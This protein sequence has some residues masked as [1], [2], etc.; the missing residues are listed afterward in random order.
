MKILDYELIDDISRLFEK[1][2][3]V[4]GTGKYG[5]K[6]A[7]AFSR[8]KIKI[9]GFCE[10]K[11]DKIFFDGE[12]VI[13]A[14]SLIQDYDEDN[15]LVI[16]ASEKYYKEMISALQVTQ[17][18]N[19][20]TYY[21][22]FLSLYLNCEAKE[23]IEPIKKDIKFFKEVSL[24][25]AIQTFFD[26]WRTTRFY[27]EMMA[28]PSLVWLLQPGKVASMTIHSSNFLKTYHFHSM[29]Y[30][31]NADGNMRDLCNQM[32]DNIKE[33]P[34][35]IITGVREPIARDISVF[36]QGTEWD[37]WPLI[38]YDNSWLYLFGDYKDNN[39]K[40]LD[41]KLLKKEI[42][43]FEK[44]LNHTFDNITRE[45]IKNKSDEFS[46]FDYEIKALFDVDIYEYPFDKE[47][48]YSIIKQDNIHILIYKCEQ[49]NQLEDIIGEFIKEPGF[50]LNST[51]QGDEKVYSYV[52]K[53][54]KEKVKLKKSYFDYY[55][56]DNSKLKHFYTDTEIEQFMDKWKEK[57]L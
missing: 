54:F 36:F 17:N 43:T 9:E 41:G 27:C 52:Y 25:T 46:W 38:R 37:I 33:R 2:L 10:T 8:M 30:A 16:I 19:L 47:K 53:K 13:S 31:F 18:M 23:M 12:K 29:A 5:R 56:A 4:Y 7:N 45:I 34:V 6:V 15:V 26:T 3:F 28:Q 40:K 20:C 57:L 48:G 44:S 1:R 39:T 24:N 50:S 51:N 14:I 11:P 42:C 32:L 21:A 49:L 35:K 55:Y 22:L